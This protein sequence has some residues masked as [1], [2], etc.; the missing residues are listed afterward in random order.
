MGRK[1][2][3]EG[4]RRRGGKENAGRGKERKGRKKEEKRTRKG[5]GKGRDGIPH[6]RYKVTPM[7]AREI[8]ARRIGLATRNQSIKE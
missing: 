3:K 1:K 4:E 5:K 2:G 7:S 8:H 6:F